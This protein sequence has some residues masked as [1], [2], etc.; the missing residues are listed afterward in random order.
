MAGVQPR[1]RNPKRL[2]QD[3]LDEGAPSYTIMLHLENNRRYAHTATCLYKITM[4]SLQPDDKK[5]PHCICNSIN[6]EQRAKTIHEDKV[7]VIVE[8]NL[9]E[10]ILCVL[11]PCKQTSGK[12]D[13]LVQ[14]G[15]Q[16]AFRT[17]GRVPVQLSGISTEPL[18]L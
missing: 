1:Y 2:H 9:K 13:V 4:A 14:P 12:L 10:F 8:H 15:E 3:E 18:N 7:I 17:I 11:E 5:L 6:E 16:I